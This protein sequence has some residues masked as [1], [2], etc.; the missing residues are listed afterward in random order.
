MAN[1]KLVIPENVKNIGIG[2]K[3]FIR[4]YGCQSN[5]R[6]TEAIAGVMEQMK[7]TKADS[8][9]EAD[10]I[11]L[12]TCTIRDNADQKVF[13]EIGFIQKSRR[14]NPNLI[15]AVC[16]CM[17]QNPEV[18]KKL[19]NSKWNVNIVFG[20]NNIHELPLLIENSLFELYPSVNTNLNDDMIVENLPSVRHNQ[21]KAFVNVMFGCSNFCTFCIV[22]FTRGKERSRSV[23]KILEEILKL[24]SEGY[25]EVTLLGQNVNNYGLDLRPKI[26]F[27]FLLKQVAK[28]KIERVRF[29]TSNPWNFDYELIIIMSKYKNIM[30]YIHLPIQSG[31]NDI[32]EKM[33]RS[34]IIE[35]YKAIIDDIKL[36]IENVSISTD[37][38]V[39]FPNESKEAFQK[40]LDLY[41]YVQY[42]NAYTFIYSKRQG[43]L[44]AS[45]KD[46]IS[47]NEKKARLAILNKKV[48]KYSKQQ[49]KKFE[50]KVVKVL[51]ESISK[52][53]NKVY[54]GYTPQ[55]KLVNILNATKKDLGNIINV[56][57]IAAKNFSLDG[58]KIIQ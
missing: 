2:K 47:D 38:I 16:G 41:D 44:A 48:T 23:D 29:T 43:T 6:D 25:K 28:T 26:N 49:N 21:Y 51:V 40:T 34:M 56:R 12:N 13:G 9:Y 33:N 55:M 32:L 11:I 5:V 45:W 3:Y 42:D 39:G 24:K 19:K 31:D 57:I 37:L 7:Y 10:F 30:P 50:G 18:V 17:V 1:N 20:T 54:S 22:P 58:I 8:L 46:S 35:E 4:T 52:N 15:L 14:E 36:K 53:N 27:A